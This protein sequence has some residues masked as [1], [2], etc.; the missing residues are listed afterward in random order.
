MGKVKSAYI[1]SMLGSSSINSYETEEILNALKSGSM[2]E[3]IG[4]I[5]QMASTNFEAVTESSVRY[6]FYE[7]LVLN[8]FSIR[9]LKNRK[10]ITLFNQA[11]SKILANSSK[12]HCV[13]IMQRDIITRV[14]NFMLEGPAETHSYCLE[15]LGKICRTSALSAMFN[16]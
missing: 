12:E 6:D 10:I 11:I 1:P 15:L 4:A 16:L 9:K 8:I 7:G 2:E 13:Q 14:H 5:E 3:K